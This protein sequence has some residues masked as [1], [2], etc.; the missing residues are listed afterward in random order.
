MKDNDRKVTICRD[1]PKRH[2]TE[3]GKK[4]YEF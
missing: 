4:E 1:H 3:R 2:V